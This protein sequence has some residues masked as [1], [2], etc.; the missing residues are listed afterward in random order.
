MV[1]CTG[2]E[3]NPAVRPSERAW[4]SSD[5]SSGTLTKNQASW[6]ACHCQT[7]DENS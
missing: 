7:G 3:L 1:T 5:M 6:R 4:I 2:T